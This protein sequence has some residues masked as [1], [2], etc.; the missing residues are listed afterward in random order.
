MLQQTQAARGPRPYERFVARFPTPAA[1]AAR[2]CATS[3]E[4]GRGLGY[5]RRARLPATRRPAAIVEHHGGAR[6][7][8]PRRDLLALPGVGPYTARAVLAS[9]SSATSASS[10]RTSPACSPE[11]SRTGRSARQRPRRWPTTW[12]RAGRGWAH[13]QAMLDLGAAHCRATP[14]CRGCPVRRRCAWAADAW[15]EPDPACSPRRRAAE[16][17]RG[18]GPAGPG[19][20][21]RPAPRPGR[22]AAPSWRRSRGGRTT[23]PAPGGWPTASWPTGWPAGPRAARCVLA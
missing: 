23:R 18:L 13:N 11:P 10:T 9:P 16:S 19:S 5:N 20:V 1:C 4:R 14:D 3:L 8:R 15:C 6:P 12:S 17:L 22:W 2:R 7:R 21:G